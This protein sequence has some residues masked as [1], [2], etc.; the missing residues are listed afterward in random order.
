[1]LVLWS[2]P[3]LYNFVASPI[4]AFAK[5]R[6]GKIK[7]RTIHDLSWL[8]SKGINSGINPEDCKLTYEF[9]NHVVELCQ[10][11]NAEFG[12]PCMLAK[13]GLTSAFHHIIV[14]LSDWHQLG[15]T[16]TYVYY[17]HSALPP[18]ILPFC[19]SPPVH[20]HQK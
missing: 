8:P 19:S 20:D 5:Y 3:P 2:T 18:I 16:F 13:C 11:F 6:N 7:V 9:S 17:L 14:H 4:G 10:A 12:K 1:M 15:S